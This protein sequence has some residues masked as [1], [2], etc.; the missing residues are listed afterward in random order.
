M[1][2]NWACSSCRVHDVELPGQLSPVIIKHSSRKQM[3]KHIWVLQD[4]GKTKVHHICLIAFPREGQVI[5]FL[6]Y[7]WP[8]IIYSLHQTHLPICTPSKHTI[9]QRVMSG[10]PYLHCVLWLLMY[11]HLK[12]TL[13]S[14][15]YTSAG[16]WQCKEQ[17]LIS[18]FHLPPCHPHH[19][20]PIP[21]YP[22]HSHL[23]EGKSSQKPCHQ[24]VCFYGVGGK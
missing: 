16:F 9:N 24:P 7:R 17:L 20:Q 14:L 12:Q 4:T 21:Q 10:I 13:L 3:R 1:K 8:C 18:H 23:H 19:C 22:Y 2:N 5:W 15:T 11:T 6:L